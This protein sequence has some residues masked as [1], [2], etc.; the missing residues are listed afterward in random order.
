MRLRASTARRRHSSRRPRSA[1]HSGAAA[2]SVTVFPSARTQE[3]PRTQRT[4]SVTTPAQAR[5]EG[6]G[7][8][9]SPAIGVLLRRATAPHTPDAAAAPPV[10]RLQ[11]C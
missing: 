2:Q 5:W 7:G 8:A 1:A 10:A 3:V 6:G 11:C 9:S 4:N